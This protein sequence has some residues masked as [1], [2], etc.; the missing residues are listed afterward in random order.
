MISRKVILIGDTS[1]GKTSILTRYVSCHFDENVQVSPQASFGTKVIQLSHYQRVKL[2]IWDTAGQEKYDSLTEM[3]FKGASAILV[4]Y[5]VSDPQ[6]FTKAQTWVSK[7]NQSYNL[8][9]VGN[10][11]DL[12][13]KVTN[14]EADQYA[15]L[16][17]IQL[18][19]VSAKDDTG[20]DEM[21]F[22]IS[23]HLVGEEIEESTRKIKIR[24]DH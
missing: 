9:L 7:L 23:Q 18:F 12:P 14:M 15:K 20:I 21:F 10:K 19:E 22:Q 16:H 2:M 11:C 6:S 13:P 3:Y 17:G 5:D 8:Y 1:V 24:K 4:V